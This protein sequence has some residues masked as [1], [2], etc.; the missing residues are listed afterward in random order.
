[1]AILVFC[2][3]KS[4]K[5]P[6]VL[7]PNFK[8]RLHQDLVKPSYD[9]SQKRLS[10][11]IA[12]H[13]AIILDFLVISRHF[14]PSPTNN[15]FVTLLQTRIASYGKDNPEVLKSIEEKKREDKSLNYTRANRDLV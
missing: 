15:G 1:M 10:L 12:F 8:S 6:V 2:L 13:P 5:I 14:C 7:V 9:H 11:Q 4:V 3:P